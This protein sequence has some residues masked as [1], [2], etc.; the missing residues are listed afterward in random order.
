MKLNKRIEVEERVRGGI[1]VTL[2]HDTVPANDR[3]V[4]A[5]K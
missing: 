3:E 1:M 5:W 4:V 2:G